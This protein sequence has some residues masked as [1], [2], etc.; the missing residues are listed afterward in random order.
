MA[1]QYKRTTQRCLFFFYISLKCW[2]S[3]PAYE[4]MVCGRLPK[5]D[6]TIADSKQLIHYFSEIICCF[7]QQ[8]EINKLMKLMRNAYERTLCVRQNQER[9]KYT[10]DRSKFKYI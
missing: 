9:A 1:S 2:I 10:N 4:N 3:F 7:Q 6:I 8:F 5:W